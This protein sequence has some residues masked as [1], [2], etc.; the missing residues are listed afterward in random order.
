MTGCHHD[1]WLPR[2]APTG[3]RTRFEVPALD[4][5]SL[6]ELVHQGHW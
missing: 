5:K 4:H 6:D 3:F 1:R 2:T